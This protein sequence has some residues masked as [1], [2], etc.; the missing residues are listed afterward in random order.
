M[1][2]CS[3][4]YFFSRSDPTRISPITNSS[5]KVLAARALSPS[6]GNAVQWWKGGTLCAG[7]LRTRLS[8]WW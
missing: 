7:L 3:V 6:V 4:T 1:L 8:F 5:R 2:S